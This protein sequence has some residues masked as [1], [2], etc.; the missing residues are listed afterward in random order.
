MREHRRGRLELAV[1]VEDAVADPDGGDLE[2]ARG[3][4]GVGRLL[5]A[6][7]D[8][9]AA[10]ALLDRRRVHLAGGGGEHH[11][12]GVAE[13]A[14]RRVGLAERGERE[15]HGAADLLREGGDQH[16]PLG[17]GRERV[18]P[19]QRLDPGEHGAALDVLAV[20]VDLGGAAERPELARAQA[21]EPHRLPLRHGAEHAGAALGRQVGLGRGQVVV[22]DRLLGVAPAITQPWISQPSAAR[23]ASMTASDSVGWP[24]M[25]RATS[26]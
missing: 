15:R 19:A 23:A 26:W 11:G 3:A 7:A 17:V 20:G 6:A 8:R 24:W 16:R 25:M 18:G 14:A 1:A 2:H 12:V 22:E 21:G 5:E 4:G 9:V 13:V 10:G